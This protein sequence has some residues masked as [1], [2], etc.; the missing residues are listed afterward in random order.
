MSMR[1]PKRKA[2]PARDRRARER[3]LRREGFALVAGAD[4][5][6]AGPLAGPLVAAAVLLPAGVPFRGVDDSKKLSEGARERAAERIR[7]RALAYRVE[8]IS[9][10]ELERIGP[11]Q[12]ALAAMTRAL[13]G[14]DPRPDYALVDARRLPALSIPHESPIGG[15]GLHTCIAAASILAK[16]HRD[17]IMSSLAERYPAYGFEGHKGYGTAGHLAALR[18]HGPCPEHRRTYGPVRDL[19]ARQGRLFC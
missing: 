7:S 13:E 14:L 16:V 11:Y 18:E 12:A 1:C 3:A 4:E 8:E 15:D 5:A 2:G 10:S 6:G 9:V 19:L 17:R